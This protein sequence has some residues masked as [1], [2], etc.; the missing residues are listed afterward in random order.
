[1][2]KFERFLGTPIYIVGVMADRI[3]KRTN[4]G[5]I[6]F[7]F[8][9]YHTGG[10]EQVHVD[11]IS[12]FRDRQPWIIITKKSRNKTHHDSMKQFGY[13][14]DF[15]RIINNQNKFFVKYYLYGYLSSLINRHHRAV[16]FS[17]NCAFFYE[18]VLTLKTAIKCDLL[19]NVLGISHL[20]WMRATPLI[21][22]RVLITQ[23]GVD[24]VLRLYRENNVSEEYK[25]RLVKIYNAISIPDRYSEKDF[26]HSLKVV[27]VGRN[28]REK[29][30]HI[31]DQI[32]QRC[33]AL[34]L[35]YSF[36]SI[37]NFEST[38]WVHSLGEIFIRDQLYSALHD[39]HILL[40]CSST[41]G[42][43]LVIPEAQA[44]GLAV[45]ATNVGGVSE[46][47]EDGKSGVLIK[48]T[49]EEEII[50]EFIGK[51][52][53]FYEWRNELQELSRAGYGYA[54]DHF[55]YE[56]FARKYRQLLLPHNDNGIAECLEKLE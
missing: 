5:G 7:F 28:A 55:S 51:L 12:A 6:F 10:A 50:Q 47:F 54:K 8:P 1:M 29:R 34:N 41:E 20:R 35:H 18:L 53:H 26:E 17:S 3:K 56:E 46:A 52:T 49:E 22:H 31:Y 25:D 38:K 40:L 42:L 37:G 14:L 39:F 45:L 13:L 27:F 11:I 23:N 32:A 9:F 16:V 2:N 21:D 36:Y 33:S 48:S 30:F 19:H 24:N 4:P 43:P 15:S 44:C